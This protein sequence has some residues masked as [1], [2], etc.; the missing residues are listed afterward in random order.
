MMYLAKILKPECL[1]AAAFLTTRAHCVDTE[2]LAKLKRL[3]GYL[4]AT[5]HREIMLRIG[6]NMT[7]RA[8]INASYGIYQG[9]EKSHI[10]CAIVVGDAGVL[11][12]RSSKQKIVT[13]SSTEAELVNL[14][15][16]AAQAIKLRNFTTG[17]EYVNG[18]VAIFQD[19]LGC[20]ALVKRGGPGSER[21]RHINIHYF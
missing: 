17:Q 1:T 15:D 3:L 19:N 9:S 5:Q 18:P 8:Y 14:S 7:I 11:S 2:D 16:S 13:K 12:A 4:R 6:D 10:G 21:F 20:M